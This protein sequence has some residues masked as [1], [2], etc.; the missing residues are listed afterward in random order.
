V[1]C[2]YDAVGSSPTGRLFF[3]MSSFWIE[4]LMSKR[5]LDFAIINLDIF[6][7]GSRQGLK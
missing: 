5:F 1:L 7:T 2:T 4:V 6:K 3:Y